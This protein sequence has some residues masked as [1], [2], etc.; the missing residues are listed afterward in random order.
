MN[1]RFIIMVLTSSF[2][3]TSCATRYIKQQQVTPVASER[4]ANQIDLLID[5]PEFQTAT[6][7]ILVQSLDTGEI[8]YRYNAEKLLIPASNEKVPTSSVA[9]LKFGPDFHYQTHFYANGTIEDCVLK[10]DLI[11]VGSGDP[12][13]GYRFCD[14]IDTCV[15]FK[16]LIST[17]IGLNIREV[18]GNLI[19]IDDIFADE[20]HGRNILS[21]YYSSQISGLM[22]NEN[23]AEVTLHVNPISNEIEFKVFPDY[24]YLNIQTD[25]TIVDNED[26]ETNINVFRETNSNMLTFSGAMK[27]E[28]EVNRHISIYN[29]TLY[30]LYGLAYEL[31]SHGILVKGELIDSDDLNSPINFDDLELLYTF[32]SPPFS[33]VIKPLMKNSINLYADSFLKLL[34]HH[35][36]E[37]G[38]F[39]EGEKVIKDTLLKFGL[40]VDSYQYRDGS[41]LSRYNYISPLHIVKIFR[42][43]HYNKYG[44]IFKECLPIAGI[45][46]TID[47]RMKG[48]RAEGKIYAKTG[49]VSN[50][51]SLSGYAMTR[52]G[53]D[54]VFSVLVNN[55]LCSVQVA[56]D[57][58]DQICIALSSF[59]RN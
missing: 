14:D 41:G 48:T 37:G 33:E 27:V 9:L 30:F 20:H 3:L 53:E 12:T 5:A 29:P 47:S 52:D 1:K 56:R 55:F 15:I 7:G 24:G 43:M 2:F 6:I 8:L 19:G 40:A 51:S 17:L 50:V 39:E 44:K 16:D 13:I 4:L 57:L 22:L 45:D 25:I 49:T 28:D 31:S 18:Q 21:S 23:S 10:G 42:G 58:Q 35:F 34:G 32:L 46:G 36:G 26:E 59:S 38:N 11:I 54:L